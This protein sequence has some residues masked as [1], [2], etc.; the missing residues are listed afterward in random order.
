MFLCLHT[1]FMSVKEEITSIFVD[2]SIKKFRHSFNFAVQGR[3]LI[4]I[5]I[6]LQFCKDSS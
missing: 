2:L 4:N 1:I 5:N 3:I 6:D